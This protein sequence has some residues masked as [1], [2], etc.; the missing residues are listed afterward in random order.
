MNMKR[1][2]PRPEKILA[3]S[4]LRTSTTEYSAVVKRKYIKSCMSDN[5]EL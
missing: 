4:F 1:D 5:T 3:V 2:L